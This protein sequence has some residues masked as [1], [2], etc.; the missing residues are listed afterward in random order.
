MFP[1]DVAEPLKDVGESYAT[2][3]RDKSR[4]N[5]LVPKEQHSLPHSDR[6]IAASGERVGGGALLC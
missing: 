3:N 2:V 6:G 4:H 1:T 5:H